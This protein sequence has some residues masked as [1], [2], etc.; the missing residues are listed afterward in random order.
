MNLSLRLV[1]AALL[2]IF[3]TVPRA[4]EVELQAFVGTWRENPSQSRHA[5][6]GALTYTFAA[7]SDG[8]ITITRANT[9]FR[10]RVKFDDMD[11]ATLGQPGR[12]GSWTKVSETIYE[13]TMKRDGVVIATARWTLSDNGTHL[14]QQ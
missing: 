1:A 10:E 7:D 8:F 14:S 13:S 11:Y 5:I 9:P 3:V 6:S 2:P 12:T 4:I